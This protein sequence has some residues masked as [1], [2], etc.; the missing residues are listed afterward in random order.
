M[1]GSRKSGDDEAKSGEEPTV[2]IGPG[3]EAELQRDAEAVRKAASG[4][5]PSLLKD[6]VAEVEAA[7]AGLAAEQAGDDADAAEEPAD[8][9]AGP[10]ASDRARATAKIASERAA[11]GAG[12]AAEHAKTGSRKARMKLAGAASDA[13]DRAASADVHEIAKTTSGLIDNT[14]PFFLAGCAF[15]FAMLGFFDGDSD[16]GQVFVVGSILFVLGAAFSTE[17][18]SLLQGRRRKAGDEQS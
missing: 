2:I 13:R 1:A 9:D 14:R 3:G 17:L 11:A 12:Q 15:L 6:P 16:V 8:A 18:T 10:R 4:G 7:E 5:E